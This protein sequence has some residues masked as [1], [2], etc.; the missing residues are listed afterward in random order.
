[1]FKFIDRHPFI[2]GFIFGFIVNKN[3]KKLLKNKITIIQ[4][5]IPNS[6]NDI[7]EKINSIYKGDV[8]LTPKTGIPV[9]QTHTGSAVISGVDDVVIKINKVEN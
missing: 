8:D 4:I 3:I 2:S 7:K 6:K 9:E 5:G 1:M